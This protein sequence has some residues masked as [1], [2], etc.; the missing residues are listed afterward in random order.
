[1]SGLYSA[2]AILIQ[3]MQIDEKIKHEKYQINEVI[4][5]DGMKKKYAIFSYINVKGA[6]H[7]QIIRLYAIKREEAEWRIGCGEFCSIP[8]NFM[9]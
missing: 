4:D 9:E 5:E 3:Q 6:N 7:D 2:H 8:T 1:M